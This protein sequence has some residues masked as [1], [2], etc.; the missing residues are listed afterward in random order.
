MT[1]TFLRLAR[2]PALL[3]FLM[4]A[5]Q[6]QSTDVKFEKK[7]YFGVWSKDR[8]AD[9]VVVSGPQKTIYMSGFGGEDADD[10]QIRHQGNVL[11]QCRYAYSKIKSRLAQHGATMGDIVKTVAYVTDVR[12]IGDYTKCRKEALGDAPLATHTFLAVSALAQPGM[13]VEVD[14]TAVIAP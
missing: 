12:F 3:A 8:F 7:N 11:E 4:T 2:M 5:A 13:L 14:I 10:G 9:A 1:T 6:A